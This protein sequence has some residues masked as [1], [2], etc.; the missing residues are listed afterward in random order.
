[1]NSKAL[2]FTSFYILVLL[3]A[4][5]H[6]EL[7]ADEAQHFLLALN[8]HDLAGLVHNSRYESHPLLWNVLLYALTRFTDDPFGM[9]LLHMVVAT[10]NTYLIFRYAPF[11]WWIKTAI[12]FGHFQLFEYGVISR[13]YALVFLFVTLYC[14]LT[15]R[16]SS[17]WWRWLMLLLLANSHLFG[18]FAACCL[19]A[20]DL[21]PDRWHSASRAEKAL[22]ATF[23]LLI[24]G[25]IWAFV[26]PPPDHMLTVLYNNA[27]WFSAERVKKVMSIP[28]K[29]FL[30][31]PDLTH[32]HLWNRNLLLD[33]VPYLAMAL[34]WM[35]ALFPAYIFRKTPRVLLVFYG[36]FA[37]IA[38]F[39]YCSPLM[40]APRHSGILYVTLIA[41][42]ILAAPGHRA[43]RWLPLFL[44]IPLAGSAVMFVA[45]HQRPFSNG[46][47]AAAFLKT[48]LPANAI[49]AMS[50]QG[51]GSP[52]SA[53]MGRPLYYIEKEGYGSF[54]TW[55]TVPFIIPEDSIYARVIRLAKDKSDSALILVMNTESPLIESQFPRVAVF[56]GSIVASED[57]R[58]YEVSDGKSAQ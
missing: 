45:D 31:I 50:N 11:S 16:R 34:G 24:A 57:Y 15:I 10:I 26:I 22:L 4:V 44:V 36:T 47:R 48:Y 46:Q 23:P 17:L 54:A 3:V 42:F 53:C 43:E 39:A 12:V 5:W 40:L 33:H 8:S 14:I 20:G 52:I 35:T 9:Q 58:I 38:A 21:L 28:V 19:F 30:H 27:G 13:N 49:V 56:D 1:M 2:L 55:N 51:S 32:P 41:C 25:I 37:L 29:G 18:L 7:W 6:H